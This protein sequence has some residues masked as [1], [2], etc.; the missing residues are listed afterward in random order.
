LTKKIKSKAGTARNKA[1]TAS[2]H[3]CGS[4][5]S[6]LGRYTPTAPSPTFGRAVFASQS[7]YMPTQTSVTAKTL[8]EIKTKINV[9]KNTKY[10]TIYKKE[11]KDVKKMFC[12]LVCLITFLPVFS[13]N[14]PN[15]ITLSYQNELEVWINQNN[16][17]IEQERQTYNGIE[18]FTKPYKQKLYPPDRVF[19]RGG[20][21]IDCFAVGRFLT[22]AESEKIS[23]QAYSCVPNIDKQKFSAF[24]TFDVFKNSLIFNP[25]ILF[26]SPANRGLNSD[27]NNK[28]AYLIFYFSSDTKYPDTVFDLQSR[29][30]VNGDSKNYLILPYSFSYALFILNDNRNLELVSYYGVN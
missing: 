22:I 9:D 11:K 21:V 18:L 13:Q 10:D 23:E 14:V 29:Q 17:F 15:D 4:G 19:G 24:S 12:F 2:P 20:S 26:D 5:F 27:F 6:R 16:V 30:L 25:A 1:V 7:P 3:K 28:N 8:C